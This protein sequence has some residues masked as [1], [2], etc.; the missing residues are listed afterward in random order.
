MPT[1]DFEW[2]VL[3]KGRCENLERICQCGTRLIHWT[4]L[5]LP[6]LLS[7]DRIMIIFCVCV[8][9]KPTELDFTK[10]P[11]KGNWKTFKKKIGF[12]LVPQRSWSFESF[13]S[14]FSCGKYYVENSSLIHDR[15][16]L[17]S[18]VFEK[19]K[20]PKSKTLRNTTDAWVMFLHCTSHLF[21]G[22]MILNYKVSALPFEFEWIL[23]PGFTERA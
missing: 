7:V 14:L 16:F 3:P 5:F 2:V 22:L 15:T 12:G 21:R 23:R 1:W 18:D 6:G 8:L 4:F 9:A 20:I 11:K 13:V 19:L 10:W 17:I